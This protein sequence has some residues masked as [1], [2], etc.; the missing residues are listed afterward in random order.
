MSFQR[1]DSTTDQIESVAA[2]L[3]EA[4][5]VA[6]RKI[7]NEEVSSMTDAEFQTACMVA[8]DMGCYDADDWLKARRRYG[9]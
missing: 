8:I 3:D 1:Q 7:R 9:T 6:A 4:L 2:A 5:P